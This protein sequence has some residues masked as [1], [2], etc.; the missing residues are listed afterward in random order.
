MAITSVVLGQAVPGNLRRVRAVVTG[1]SSYPTGGYTIT[2]ALFGLQYLNHAVC[3][4]PVGGSAVAS[5]AALIQTT[6][7][8]LFL[9]PAGT[10]V[11]AATNVSAI[12][13]NVEG[14]G[15]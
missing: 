9:A 2:P 3:T 15:N 12:S 4:G 13:F 10:E 11:T 8:L 6:N 14:Y 1:D 7:K 5:D